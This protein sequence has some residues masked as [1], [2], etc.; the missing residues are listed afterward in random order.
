[1]ADYFP[2]RYWPVGYPYWPLDYWVE[3][4]AVTPLFIET[5]ALDTTARVL[6][7]DRTGRILAEVE[8]QVGPLSWRLNGVGKATLTFAK[9][10]PKASEDYLQFGNRVLIQF[11][12]GLPDWGGV[13]DPPRNWTESSIR[14]TAYSGEYLLG[15]R[16]TDRG[17]YFDS[18]T[19]G[20]IF[21]QLIAEA[22]AVAASGVT[23]GTVWDAGS[24]HSPEYHFANLLKVIRE[25]LTARLSGGDFAVLAAEAGGYVTFTAHFYERRGADKPGVV[26]LED[27]NL[28]E[29]TLSEQGPIVNSWVTVGQGTTWGEERPLGQAQDAD[30]IA[31][32]G[33]R[34][35]S[36]M[37]ADTSAQ[38]TLDETA[39]NLLAESARPRNV[40]TLAATDLAPARF[41]AYDLGDA[42]RVLLHSYGFGGYD[43]LVRVLAREYDPGRGVCKLVVQEV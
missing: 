5:A 23:V 43:G 42:L 8:P 34:Q 25:S 9:S 31:A 26:L 7:A 12:N 19:V 1:M 4:G 10:D 30:S 15:W 38:A 13:I 29:V 32:Y 27:H 14:V 21:Q 11:A 41:A 16:Q 18:A 39:A 2:S 6:V 20:Y 35:D 3:Y 36:E 22:N 24:A 33:L 17:R 40:L 28:A 37:H